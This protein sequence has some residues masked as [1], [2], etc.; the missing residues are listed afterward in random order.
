MTIQWAPPARAELADLWRHADSV[1]RRAIAAG[2]H[3]IDKH[4]E[5]DPE[6]QGDRARM[7]VGSFSSVQSALFFASTS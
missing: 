7:I 5:V 3:A 2:A 1:E 6:N 4:L